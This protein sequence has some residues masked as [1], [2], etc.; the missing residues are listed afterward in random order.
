MTCGADPPVS[1]RPAEW[2]RTMKVARRWC[3][4]GRV[5]GVGFRYH[6]RTNAIA[7][8]VTGWIRTSSDGQ[9]MV[10]GEGDEAQLGVLED[11]ML[12]ATYA[13]ATIAERTSVPVEGCTSFEFV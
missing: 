12:G 10:H 9:I 4:Q 8:G 13:A 1:N 11:R 6:V 7:L 3:V 2:S 5:Q